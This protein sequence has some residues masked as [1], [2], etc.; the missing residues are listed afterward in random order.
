MAGDTGGNVNQRIYG[1]RLGGSTRKEMEN[2]Q[3]GEYESAKHRVL[4]SMKCSSGFMKLPD[5]YGRNNCE[6]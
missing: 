1:Y 3:S 2:T 5:T 4:A 6:R